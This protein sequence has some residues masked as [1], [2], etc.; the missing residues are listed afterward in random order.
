M[1]GPKLHTKRTPP[2]YA[3]GTA[4]KTGSHSYNERK[5][6]QQQDPRADEIKINTTIKGVIFWEICGIFKSFNN[7]LK[8]KQL[9]EVLKK[10]KIWN[11]LKL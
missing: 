3:C 4:M 8:L 2:Q 5:A 1:P 9:Q 6:M 7:S 10:K 11:D